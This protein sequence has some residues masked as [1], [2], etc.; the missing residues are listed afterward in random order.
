VSHAI[1]HPSPTAVQCEASKRLEESSEINCEERSKSALLSSSCFATSPT[2]AS[3]EISTWAE[4]VALCKVR[5]NRLTRKPAIGIRD[6][7]ER[8]TVIFR[9]RLRL[10]TDTN[11]SN[12]RTAPSPKVGS[13]RLLWIIVPKQ[14][15]AESTVNRYRLFRWR[16]I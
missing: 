8:M 2:P 11:G 7:K 12:K 1:M 10:T 15:C 6:W 3:V 14:V 5:S 4:A 9:K 13:N 16:E